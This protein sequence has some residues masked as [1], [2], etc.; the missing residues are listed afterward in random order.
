MNVEQD[1]NHKD[2]MIKFQNTQ[3]EERS[4]TGQLERKGHQT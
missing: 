2:I 1:K 3:A 4:P